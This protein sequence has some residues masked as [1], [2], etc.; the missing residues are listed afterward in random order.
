MAFKCFTIII[1]EQWPIHENAFSQCDNKDRG[2]E[3][4][5]GTHSLKKHLET[6]GYASVPC[7]NHCHYEI[8]RKDLHYHLHHQCPRRPHTCPHCNME[9]ECQ[10]MRTTHLQTCQK[11][12]IPCQNARCPIQLPHCELPTHLESCD[13]NNKDVRS[14]GNREYEE[15]A[16]KRV[17]ND[18]DA[19]A[20]FIFLWMN[21]IKGST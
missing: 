8:L 16:N 1:G 7:I 20:L 2:C 3:W 13:Y 21:T 19:G 6:C 18:Q 4:I 15:D 5:G 11:L 9:G 10:E 12:L 17:M 14:E